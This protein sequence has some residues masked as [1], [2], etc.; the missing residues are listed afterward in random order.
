[1]KKIL[2]GIMVAGSL[3]AAEPLQ[4]GAYYGDI[5]VKVNNYNSYAENDV[6]SAGKLFLYKQ[7]KDTVNYIYE[8]KVKHITSGLE[9]A[10]KFAIKKSSKYFAID[11]VT[12]QV[13][14]TDNQVIITTNY[15]VLAFD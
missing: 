10:K 8:T 9:A 13:I 2:W 15:N 5:K 6:S 4:Y 3:F 1:M 14:V 11:N 7:K 12:H